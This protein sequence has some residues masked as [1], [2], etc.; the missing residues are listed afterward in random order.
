LSYNNDPAFVICASYN[1]TFN[2]AA[3]PYT[4]GRNN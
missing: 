3:M 4:P 2:W 1:H